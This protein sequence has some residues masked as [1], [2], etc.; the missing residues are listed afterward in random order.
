MPATIKFHFGAPQMYPWAPFYDVLD[1]GELQPPEATKITFADDGDRR[2]VL[3]GDFTI[4]NGVVTGGAVTGFSVYVGS[5]E[6]IAG[7]SYDIAAT[8]LVDAIEDFQNDNDPFWELIWDVPLVQFGSKQDDE[9]WGNDLGGKILAGGGNDFVWGYDG[10]ETIKGGGGHDHLSGGWGLDKLVG[11]TGK[12]VFSFYDSQGGVDRIMDF[13]VKQDLIGLNDSNFEAFGGFVSADEFAIGKGTTAHHA[14]IYDK[15]TGALFYDA[16]GNGGTDP[17]Q[18]AQL[19]A[20]LNL[21][22]RNFVMY[23]DWLTV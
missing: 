10:N 7:S 8:E 2:L 20:G 14:L 4:D 1:N 9:M 15:T 11:G 5:L 13:D 19:S 23:D 21:T 22:A 12:D 18:F 3:H 6:V 17:V 16:D